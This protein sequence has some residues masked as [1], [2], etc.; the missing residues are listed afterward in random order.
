MAAAR[1]LW[2]LSGTS[3]APN[4][5]G[6]ALLGFSIVVSGASK[7]GRSLFA[8][9]LAALLVAFDLLMVGGYMYGALQVN[10]VSAETLM[11]PH[12]LLCVLLSTLVIVAR[13]AKQGRLFADLVGIGIGSQIVRSVLPFATL[14]PFI[15]FGMV[16]YLVDT[17]TATRTN[18]RTMAAA[19]E[20]LLALGMVVWMASRIN[21]L[22]RK[23]RDLSLTDELTQIYN[24]RGF[25]F[26]AQQAFRS[27]LRAN[28]GLTA[29]F[30][31]LDGLKR[32]NDTIGHDAGSAMIRALATILAESFRHS[33]IVGRVGGDEFVVLTT[34]DNGLARKALARVVVRVAEYNRSATSAAP[35][36]FS[37]GVAEFVHGSSESLDTLVARAD[38]AMYQDKTTRKVIR[39]DGILS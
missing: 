20:S 11:S 15:F 19:L 16:E 30:F 35:L 1:T 3:I 13:R 34:R 23:V 39:E 36:S 25:Y 17:G 10:G 7:G 9:L 28:T 31:D 37:V 8:D 4:R 22:E 27:A 33:D 18:A 38:S 21:V 32:A 12:S 29:L 2:K 24:R 26:L 6:L 5:S 14:L